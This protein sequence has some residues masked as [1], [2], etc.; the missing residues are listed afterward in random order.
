MNGFNLFDWIYKAQGIAKGIT[1]NYPGIDWEDVAQEMSSLLVEKQSQFSE[2]HI[3]DSYVSTALRHVGNNY[4]QKEYSRK[5]FSGDSFVYRPDDV[6]EFLQAYYDLSLGDMRAPSYG[7]SVE[8]DDHLAI[9]AD[10]AVAVEHSGVY[11]EVIVNYFC[12]GW[13]PTSD[14]E[15]QQFSRAIRKVTK[16]LNDN[17]EKQKKN[18]NGP[19]SRKAMTNARAQYIIK[20]A[21]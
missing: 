4:C 21:V 18:H 8:S 1:R 13:E 11:R 17:R 16:L 9:Y 10:I 3:K 6:R 15:R 14:A 7:E 2:E 20:E 19:G 5:F 12:E